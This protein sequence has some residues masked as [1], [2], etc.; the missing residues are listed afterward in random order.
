M[1]KWA[2]TIYMKSD[3]VLKGVA[4]WLIQ[5]SDMKPLKDA[6][7][8]L[9]EAVGKAIETTTTDVENLRQALIDMTSALAEAI[10]AIVDIAKQALDLTASRDRERAKWR[11]CNA[12]KIRPLLLDK[13]SKVHRCRNA[14]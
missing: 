7:D 5:Q 4:E 1:Y 14:C 11:R 10:R 9:S 12:P 6:F 3:A 13:R 8:A 2:V